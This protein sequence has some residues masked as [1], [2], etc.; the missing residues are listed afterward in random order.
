MREL[1]VLKH[2]IS[3]GAELWFPGEGK[4]T[5][6]HPW[7]PYLSAWKKFLDHTSERG[8]QEVDEMR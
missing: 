6:G 3:G 2:W 7:L 5:K 1:V 8:V 4:H